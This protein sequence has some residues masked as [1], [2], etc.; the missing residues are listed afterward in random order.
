MIW[1]VKGG[2][3]DW[4]VYISF[5]LS[6]SVSLFFFLAGLKNPL[7]HTMVSVEVLVTNSCFPV[8]WAMNVCFGVHV[9]AFVYASFGCIWLLR[10]EL[11]QAATLL[12][13]ICIWKHKYI[14]YVHSFS[15]SFNHMMRDGFRRRLQTEKLLVYCVGAQY[16]C[17]I[18]EFCGCAANMGIWVA[19]LGKFS[20][21]FG[22]WTC[23]ADCF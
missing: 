1:G 9:N 15:V 13:N 18:H 4:I 21:S 3:N 6:M 19:L 5:Y 10:I 14:V 23:P 20:V 16:Q 7:L 8:T 11:S 2:A 12:Y 22:Q 17:L